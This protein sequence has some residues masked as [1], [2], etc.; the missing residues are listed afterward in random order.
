MIDRP[1]AAGR[2]SS[3]LLCAGVDAA[4]RVDSPP[5]D[6]GVDEPAGPGDEPS[7]GGLTVLPL[8]PETDEESCGVGPAPDPPEPDPLEPDPL[9]PDPLE[10]DPL[11]PDPL[12]PDPLEPDPL[13][14]DPEPPEPG[15]LEP[16][17]LDPEPGVLGGGVAEQ[18]RLGVRAVSQDERPSVCGTLTTVRNDPTE[19]VTAE[20]IVVASGYQVMVTGRSESRPVPVTRASSAEVAVTAS[21]HGDVGG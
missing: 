15:P 8:L 21:A 2:W 13:E 12:E 1:N 4:G 19:S 14:P 11:E 16:D 18:V 3:A 9:E 17:P 20:P 10:P 5:V 7:D 6:D